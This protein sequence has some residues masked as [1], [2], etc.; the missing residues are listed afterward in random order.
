MI[1][2]DEQIKELEVQ[3]DYHKSLVTVH[4]KEVYAL[5]ERLKKLKKGRNAKSIAVTDH[6][7]VKYMKRY[8]DKVYG[9]DIEEVR[10]LIKV[11]ITEESLKIGGNGKITFDDTTYVVKN[12]TVVTIYNP[13]NR[14]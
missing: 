4:N 6:A 8:K 1:D 14:E 12:H 7:V 11:E 10:N 3:I 9:L 5:R 2:V 13:N